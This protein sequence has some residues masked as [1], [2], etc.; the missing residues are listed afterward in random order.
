M[1]K[2][3][4]ELSAMEINRL[5]APGLVSVG[6]VPGLSFQIT[7]TGARS[8]ILR[9]KIGTKRRDMGLGPFPGVTL[10]QAREKARQAR[11]TIDQGH[12]PILNRE[13]AR[14][15]LRAAQASAITFEDAADKFIQNKKA[16]WSNEKH[17]SQWVATL[18]TYA[19]PVSGKLHVQDVH[20][21][22]ILKILEPIWAT[23][24]ETATRVR[25][26]IENVLDWA[27]AKKYRKGENPARWRGHLDKL[28]PAPKKITKVEH[29]PAVPVD[30]IASVYSSLK[31][32]KGVAARALEFTLL[33]AARSGEVR[34]ATWAEFDF[35]KS[36]W[37]IPAERMKARVEHRV[38]LT[39]SAAD[40]LRALPRPDGSEFVF[41]APRGGQLSDMSLT[42]VMRRM[43]LTE[44]PHGLR[45]TFRDWAAERTNFPRDLAEKA[46]AHTLESK[47]ESSYQRGDMLEKRRV[48][49][50]AWAKFLA[51]PVTKA[52]NITTL[53]RHAA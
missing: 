47:V 11:E 52:C 41:A 27:A 4:R 28:L 30:D 18:E 6:G 43:E 46:L 5:K 14:S 40:I 53:T 37:V 19:F 17:A 24:T 45:S 44:V 32:R 22:H 35:D 8:W 34:G 1:P 38:P 39:E 13:R 48:M 26:R 51:T 9:V 15:E 2:I 7:P 42:A 12:D 33:T 21:A 49:M 50:A 20:D 10:A 25:G 3:A 16:E 29:H 36:L 23:K 31:A